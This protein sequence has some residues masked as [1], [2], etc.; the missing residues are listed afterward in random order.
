M[1][2]VGLVQSCGGGGESG[3]VCGKSVLDNGVSVVWG[4]V[5]IV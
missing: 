5:R 1:C 2:F 4:V 3:I